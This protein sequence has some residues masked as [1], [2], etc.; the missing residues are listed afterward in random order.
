MP[1]LAILTISDSRGPDDDGSGNTLANRASASGHHIAQRAWIKDERY[2]VR[3]Q[4]ANWC[5]DPEIEVIISTGGTG[6]TGRDVTPQAVAPLIDLEI[7][8]FGELFRYLSLA[9][10]GSSTVQSR[11]LAGF[12][13]GKLLF[14]LPGST[15]ACE[16]AWDQIIS[17]QLDAEFRPCNFVSKL[18]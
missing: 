5:C 9:Q 4:I 18:G 1:N 11:A 6:F 2:Q 16:L 15:G 10:I 3:A 14:C 8:G 13:A 17:E 7:P 12:S